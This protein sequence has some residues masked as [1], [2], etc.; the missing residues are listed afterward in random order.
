MSGFGDMQ[1]MM[2][3][4]KKMQEEF[5]QLQE[6]LKQKVVEASSGGGAVTVVANGAK[7]IVSIKINKDFVDTNDIEML[8]DLVTAAVNE[9]LN[10]AQEMAEQETKKITGSLGINLPG[11]L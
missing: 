1:E 4:A 11:L 5:M 8:Q 9:A 6:E 3:K 7:Q 10:A 2:K